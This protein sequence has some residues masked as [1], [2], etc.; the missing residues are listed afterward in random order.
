MRNTSLLEA[1]M[2][3]FG[4]IRM[5]LSVSLIKFSHPFGTTNA[6]KSYLIRRSTL[7][8]TVDPT[9]MILGQSDSSAYIINT[10]QLMTRIHS[11]Y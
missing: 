2:R 8:N 9:F 3:A 11:F 5:P 7:S 4:A 6:T 10:M 1:S